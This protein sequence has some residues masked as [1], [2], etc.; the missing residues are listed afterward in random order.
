[1]ISS[2]S[3]LAYDVGFSKAKFVALELAESMVG[4]FALLRSHKNM[5][6]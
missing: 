3:R 4:A 1:M 5:D 6:T 2:T